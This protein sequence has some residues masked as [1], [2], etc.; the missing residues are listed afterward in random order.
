MLYGKH[1]PVH[2]CPECSNDTTGSTSE[3]GCRWALCPDCYGR[4]LEQQRDH[5]EEELKNI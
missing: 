2:K 1:E 3:G 4:M 5:L